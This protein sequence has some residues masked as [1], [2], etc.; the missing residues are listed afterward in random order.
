MFLKNVLQY[1]KGEIKAQKQY[2]LAYSISPAFA[3]LASSNLFSSALKYN[4][5][6]GLI[7]VGRAVF[8]QRSC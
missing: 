3:I 1:N 6:S 7:L 4:S 5:A 8:S 2:A